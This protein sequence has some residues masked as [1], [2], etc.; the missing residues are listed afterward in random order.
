MNAWNERM[1]WQ[2]TIYSWH[3][4]R[5]CG[6]FVFFYSSTYYA[7]KYITYLFSIFFYNEKFRCFFSVSNVRNNFLYLSQGDNRKYCWSVKEI[8]T[9]EIISVRSQQPFSFERSI[10]GRIIVNVVFQQRPSRRGRLQFEE[11]CLY[12]YKLTAL[13]W[14]H[15]KS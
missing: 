9:R 10:L 4:I 12:F 5:L 6:P 2:I 7:L 11:V 1:N 3:R 15:V 8:S 14:K 13:S